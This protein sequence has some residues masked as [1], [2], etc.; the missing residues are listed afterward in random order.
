MQQLLEQPSSEGSSYA[1]GESVMARRMDGDFVEGTV[2]DALEGGHYLVMWNEEEVAAKLAAS[3]LMPFGSGMGLSSERR[4][5]VAPAFILN[6]F[7]M[8]TAIPSN[9]LS[10]VQMVVRDGADVNCTDSDGNSPLN[11]AVSNGAS[12]ALIQFLISRGA[13][14]NFVG[15]AGSALQIA[16]IQDNVEAV[17]C[18][19]A[20]GADP[21]L[22]DLEAAAEESVELLRES[23]IESE[24]TPAASQSPLTPEELEAHAAECFTQ[25]L[26]ALLGAMANT[27]SPKLHKRVLMVLCFAVQRATAK[28]LGMLTSLQLGSLLSALRALLS[29]GNSLE[30]FAALRML[31]AGLA[32][33]PALGSAARRH[34]ID[35][36]LNELIDS[37]ATAAAAP[38]EEQAALLAAAG[39]ASSR[40]QSMSLKPQDIL[41]I[42]ERRRLCWTRCRSLRP[43]RRCSRR[44]ARCRRK[45]K[46]RSARRARSWPR[47]SSARRLPL[48]TSSSKA[49]RS[50]GCWASSRSPRGRP[51]CASDGQTLSALLARGWACP[52]ARRSNSSSPYCTTRSPRA[53]RCRCTHT[54]RPA[55]VHT[56][57]SHSRSP[58]RSA[59]ILWCMAPRARPRAAAEARGSPSSSGLVSAAADTA[60]GAPS[61]LSLSI[62]PLVRVG[63]VQQHLLRTTPV[64]DTAY[65]AFC[66]RLL[67]CV[68]EERPMPHDGAAVARP[69]AA[70]WEAAAASTRR[71]RPRRR[72]H[73]WWRRAFPAGDGDELP[74][75]HAA[76]AAAAHARVR[77]RARGRRRPGDAPVPNHRQGVQGEPRAEAGC[78]AR[79]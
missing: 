78:V 7:L 77:R 65:E 43:S 9:D 16:A 71:R 60:D 76:E 4:Q 70:G 15:A 21:G 33:W 31:T 66:T 51:S 23:L 32:S 58:Y 13:H 75:G 62:D 55:T 5:R 28:Q 45:A 46:S 67:G 52:A 3:E 36:L 50:P 72:C 42:A 49:A 73:R 39:Q 17:R 37:T 1:V 24:V 79:V 14:V 12:V 40:A 8:K 6:N 47:S 35:L 38:E 59:F 30:A 74:L 18:L 56:H 2:L 61:M 68:V 27:Q 22:V 57:S 63:Q 25:L 48:H 44:C 26:P 29:S 11:L 53:S 20:H 19:L 69:A 10:R 41:S 34:G 64:H 54:P